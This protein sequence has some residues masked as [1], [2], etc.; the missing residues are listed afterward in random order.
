MNNKKNRNEKQVEIFLLHRQFFLLFCSKTIRC[1]GLLL[2]GSFADKTAVNYMKYIY[3]YLTSA[4]I[5]AHT[6][7]HVMSLFSVICNLFFFYPHC[8]HIP[9]CPG[10]FV[11]LTAHSV[12]ILTWFGCYYWITKGRITV[13]YDNI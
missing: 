6:N 7:I 10:T 9:F 3:M 1:L 2:T 11:L 8:C 5:S 4:F 12:I 13:R